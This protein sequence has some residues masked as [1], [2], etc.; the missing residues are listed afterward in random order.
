MYMQWGMRR[1]EEN[2]IISGNKLCTFVIKTP[3]LQFDDLVGMVP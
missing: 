1:S 2:I 3:G